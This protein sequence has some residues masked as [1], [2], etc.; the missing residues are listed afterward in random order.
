MT[1][2]AQSNR[3][4]CN[5]S[6]DSYVSVRCENGIWEEVVHLSLPASFS[7]IKGPLDSANFIKTHSLLD[8][9]FLYMFKGQDFFICP[10]FGADV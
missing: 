6:G 3:L 2:N 9:A 10:I 4:D 8:D 1:C 7:D 5:C